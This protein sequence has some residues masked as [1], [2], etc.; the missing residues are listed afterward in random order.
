MLTTRAWSCSLLIWGVASALA[1]A[2]PSRLEPIPD[3]LV[4][5]TF[6]DSVAS[7]HSVVG[8]L[9]KRYGFGATFF[10]TEGFSFPTN[11]LDYMTWG[12]IA[13]L[14]RDGFEIG[15]HT[16]DHLAVTERTL[17]RLRE[18]VEAINARCAE[19]GIPRPV[20]F[21]YPGNAIHPGAVPLLR[22]LGFQ[23]ARRGS[24]P[25][26]PYEAGRGLAFEPGADHPLLI[27][28][29]GDARPNWTLA[30]FQRAVR[31]ATNG[32]VAVLQFHGVPD[33]EHPWVHTPP[34]RFA[35]YMGWLHAN[36][37]R[38]IAL[39]DLA[40]YVDP[41]DA[42]ADPWAVIKRRRAAAEV[43]PEP[44]AIRV[45]SPY[46]DLKVSAN[47]PAFLS[48]SVD[49]LGLGKG[50]TNTLRSPPVAATPFSARH[51]ERDGLSIEYRRANPDA[52][53]DAGWRFE[54]SGKGF[55]LKSQWSETEAPEPLAFEFEPQRCHVTLLGRVQADGSVRLPAVLHLPDQ[56]SFRLTAVGDPAVALGYDARRAGTPYVRVTFPPATAAQPRVEYRWEVVAIPPR[57]PGVEDDP[58][59]HGFRRNWLNILQ[60]NPRLRVLANH[61]ASDTCA[62]CL[63]E[64]ADLAR[65]TPPL[66]DHLTALDLIRDSLDHYLDGLPGYGLPG[67]VGFDLGGPP[68]TDPPFLDSYPSLLIAAGQYVAGSDDRGWLGKRYSGLRAWA[69]T[70][71]AM[72]HDGNGL[73]EY[74]YSGNSGSWS[75]KAE[76]RPS[77]WWDCIG[78]GHEDAYANALAYR[79]LRGMTK[80]AGQQRRTAD[81]VRYRKAADRLR[82][83]FCD[84]F[85]PPASGVLAG[86]RSADGQLHDYH[87]LWV[88][89]IAIHYGLVP[90]P[91]ANAIMDRLL[92]RLKQVGYTRFDLGLPGNL[93]P[94]PRA[95]YVHLDSRWGGGEQ[96]DDSDGFQKYENGGA[97]AC[98]AYFTLAA[99]YDLGRRDE[100]DQMLFPLLEAFERGSFQGRAANGRS[101]DWKAWD[102]TPWGYEGF[103]VDTYYA[104]L[105]VLTRE[106]VINT[107][108]AE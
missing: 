85:Y 82:A 93:V 56:G 40:R 60:L 27:P 20:S 102:G 105:A 78:F 67:H 71:L 91:K 38:V 35:D 46:L 33:R 18:Q 22:E 21:A 53:A 75:G 51:E 80:M 29:A 62:F 96:A 97:T 47:Q 66:A 16:R 100:A 25:E 45:T 103:L 79:A 41:A 1:L 34:E 83:V 39:R 73:F 17:G 98:F 90:P 6:D 87:F 30:D 95:D 12:Q 42:P 44:G 89:G 104:L 43:V 81:A 5:L 11:K 88:N 54:I 65:H 13:E 52:Q 57:L 31:Q 24:E 101:H 64:Y 61:A 77:N 28:T 10:I 9:L 58:R 84:T 3:K 15:N 70:L 74:P 8:P 107:V 63:Y 69:D 32:R 7:H 106:G 48:L 92:A 19:Q 50:G 4:V 76:K 49:S 26:V 23:F 108:D 99:L 68:S 59:F 36:G 14:H 72:D 37:Y 86:W 94:V 2:A 55:R